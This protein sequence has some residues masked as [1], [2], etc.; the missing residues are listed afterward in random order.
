VGPL[1]Q[2]YERSI[3]EFHR[4]VLAYVGRAS[5]SPTSN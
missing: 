2:D 1:A 4:N 3:T 5:S